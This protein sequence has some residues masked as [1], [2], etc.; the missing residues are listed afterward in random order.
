[1]RSFARSAFALA[2]VSVAFLSEAR[3]D[4]AANLRLQLDALRGKIAP[5]D[6]A[7]ADTDK[8]SATLKQQADDYAA[9][10]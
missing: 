1:M 5:L 9:K 10:V 8:E 2:F 3:A 7:L 6:A 4:D